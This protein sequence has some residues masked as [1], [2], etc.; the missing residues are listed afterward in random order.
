ME[1]LLILNKGTEEFGVLEVNELTKSKD[2]SYGETV[3]KFAGDETDFLNL[4]YFSQSASRILILL[5]EFG[6]KDDLDK[7]DVDI[8]IDKKFQKKFKIVAQRI[9]KHNFNSVDLSKKITTQIIKKYSL[10]VDYDSPEIIFYLYL[11]NDKGYLGIDLSGFDLSKRQYKIFNHPGSLKGTTAYCLVR[12]SGYK[13]NQIMIDPFMGSGVIPIEAALFASGMSVRYYEKDKFELN[14]YDWFNKKD[15]LKLDKK[16]KDVENIFCYD[17]LFKYLSSVKKNSKLAGVDKYINMSKVDVDWID[18]KFDKKSVD[19]I[20]S[21]PP[22]ISKN[23]DMK[24]IEKVYDELFYQADYILKKSGSICLLV[25][26]LNFVEEIAKKR[27]F[28]I[29]S[30]KTIFQ[31]QEEFELIKLMKSK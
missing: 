14:N 30:N 5:S 28:K 19:I 12:Y 2:V 29:I 1:G 15:F 21:D 27:K 16:I 4:S 26:D 8:V 10:E 22:R 7:T 11:Y 13:P 17:Y 3:V 20:I 6:V 18:T 9:G 31:G 23:K 24:G 25:N